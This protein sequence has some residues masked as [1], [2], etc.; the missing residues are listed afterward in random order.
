MSPVEPE[1]HEPR[2][3]QRVRWI[4]GAGI[5]LAAGLA[6][7]LGLSIWQALDSELGQRLANGLGAMLWLGPTVLVG[8]GVFVWLVTCSR[9][10]RRTRIRL[11]ATGLTLA[12]AA[13]VLFRFDSFSGDLFPQFTWRWSH[14][15]GQLSLRTPPSSEAE[16]HPQLPESPPEASLA[17]ASDSDYPGFLG[18]NRTGVVAGPRL[19]RDWNRQPPRALWQH[20]VGLGWS[21]FAVMGHHAVTQE[22]RGPEECVVAYDLRTGRELWVHRDET[23]F[24]GSGVHG[25]GP[26]ATPMLYQGRVYALGATGY[27]N[28]LELLTGRQ[29]W[30][31]QVLPHPETDNLQWGMAGSPLI[32]GQQVIIAPGL[33]PGRSVMAFDQESGRLAWS[34]GD[35]PAAY[36]SPQ[37]SQL[38]G[39]NQILIFNGAGLSAHAPDDGHV[40]WTFPWVTQGVSMVNVAQ[41]LVLSRSVLGAE[42]DAFLISSGYSQGCALLSIQ[43][44]QPSMQVTELWRNKS[45]KS[46]FSNM[47][48]LDEFVYGLDDGILVCLEART[49][50][51]RWKGGRY[52]HGQL[53]LVADLLLVQT[54]SGDVALVA[55]DPKAFQELGTFAALPSKTWNHPALAG[56]LLLVRNDRIAACYELPVAEDSE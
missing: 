23:L 27:F 43:T 15:A 14:A 19:A 54:E 34:A 39:Q 38:D 37:A 44:E 1:P 24:T 52:G 7:G 45:L 4:R 16:K 42:H 41:P 53:L 18:P 33:K 17:M 28:C 25:D 8:F 46:K 35:A 50:K 2:S 22:Q 10:N 21:G 40:L 3:R 47:V 13:C 11:G 5:G 26:R 55:P 51:R 56:N 9:I 30:Q 31:H 29:L 48:A 49:G 36:S 12:I 32:V 20:S 6:C